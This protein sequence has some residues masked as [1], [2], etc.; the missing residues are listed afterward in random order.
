MR[1]PR[2]FCLSMFWGVPERVQQ[3]GALESALEF[4]R[5]VRFVGFVRF[6]RFAAPVLRG[7]AP[8]A[9]L[10]QLYM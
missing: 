2:A 9:I 1:S 6:V 7:T 3:G 4:V 8:S 10:D 5:F